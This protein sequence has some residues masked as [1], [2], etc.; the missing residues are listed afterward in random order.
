MH[1]TRGSPRHHARVG[2]LGGRERFVA[3]PEHRG[4][5][6]VTFLCDTGERYVSS[7]LFQNV[8]DT[9]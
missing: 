6:I 1:P 3:R 8:R 5:T 7:E 2:Q 9:V 4:Q